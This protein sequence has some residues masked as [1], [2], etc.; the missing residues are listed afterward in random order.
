VSYSLPTLSHPLVTLRGLRRRDWRGLERALSDNRAWLQPWE[1]TSP[2]RSLVPDDQKAGIRMLLAHAKKGMGLPMVM[3]VDGQLVGQLNV[4]QITYGSLASASLGYWVIEEYAGRGITPIA[5][6]LATDYLFFERGLHRM[7]ICIRPEN[8]ASFRIVEKLGFRFEGLRR[9]FIHIDGRWR[10][11]LCFA[12]TVDEVP[13]GV[14]A[15]FEKGQV[16]PGV[17]EIPEL[18]KIQMRTP[19]HLPPR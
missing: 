13:R 11:H 9:R 2:V 14:L 1:A 3:E 4:S 16:P 7:E 5:V 12:L 10:D 8:E 18:V 19:L 6:A 17:A 15:R